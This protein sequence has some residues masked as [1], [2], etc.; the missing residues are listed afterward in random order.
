MDKIC[1]YPFQEFLRMIES[2]HGSKSPGLVLGG[3]MVD[4]AVSEIPPGVLFDAICETKACLPDAIQLFTPCSYGNGWLKVMDLG[5]FALSLYNKRSGE[6]VRVYVDPARLRDWS[7]IRNWLY[8][9]KPK[10]EQDQEL[11]I[12]E[13]KLAGRSVLGLRPIMVKP[14]HV[15]KVGR[16][17]IV[18][19]AACGEPYPQKD[20]PIC[21]ACLGESPYI[22][23]VVH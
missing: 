3:I 12:A 19:C 4:Y 21:R 10:S 17:A 18:D 2:F 13:M 8:K 11:L 15:G 20:G 6:G 14:Q 5:R 7:E 1:G 22:E 16:G 23:E 9:L